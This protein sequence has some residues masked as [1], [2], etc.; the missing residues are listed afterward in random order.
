MK[1]VRILFIFF[2]FL[3]GNLTYCQ[4]KIHRDCGPEKYLNTRSFVESEVLN[5][6]PYNAIVHIN[7]RGLKKSWGTATF[8]NENTLITARHV[9]DKWLL[10]KIIVY[11]NLFENGKI[12]T[13][14]VTLLKEDIIIKNAPRKKGSY[15]SDDISLIILSETGRNK[16]QPIYSGSLEVTNYKLLDL[17]PDEIVSLTGYPVDLAESGI[18]H[19]DILSNK[20]TTFKEL[21]FPKEYELVGYPLFTCSGDSGAPLWVKVKDK[22]Y[23][24]GIHHGGPEGV[25][26][27]TPI[28]LNASALIPENNW[29]H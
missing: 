14:E 26:E 16:L 21:I 24:I 13:I 4:I 1:A 10:N 19:S 27:F 7:V 23:I 8:I 25:K 15:F 17:H 6:K 22:Y 12:K 18:D 11:K 29:I 3:F 28:E 20:S 9:V 5:L 2:L